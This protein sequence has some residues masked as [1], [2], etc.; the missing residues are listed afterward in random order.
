[1]KHRVCELLAAC[2]VF[3]SILAS[4]AYGAAE[5]AEPY[6]VGP[7]K[8]VHARFTGQAGTIAQYGDSITHSRAFFSQL[9]WGDYKGDVDLKR[10]RRLAVE[11]CKDWKGTEH[12]N[13]GGWTVN[14]CL[15][16]VG[17]ALKN[18]NPAVAFLMIGTNDVD[19]PADPAKANFAA[20]LTRLVQTIL[21]NGTVVVL[22]TIPP[23]RGREAAVER[24]NEVIREVARKTQVPL[25]DYYAEIIKRRPKDWDGS[26]IS[27]DGVHPSYPQEYQKDFTEKGLRES[28]YTLRD[29][30][31]V[32]TY[33]QLAD[34]LGVGRKN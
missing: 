34:S 27:P 28:G 29:Y 33:F 16:A 10:F 8:R 18:E 30:L 13:M 19:H 1:M 32:K 4:M 22:H 17:P 3:C 23:K 14:D 15:N 26:L 12:C 25:I 9:F 21:D 2:S 24:Y 11:S 6:W 20:N 31:L 5:K 7:M